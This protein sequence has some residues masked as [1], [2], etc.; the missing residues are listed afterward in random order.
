MIDEAQYAA[1][2]EELRARFPRL[3]L[4]DKG[5]SAMCKAIDALLRVVTLGGQ[6]VFMTR[7]VTT[8]GS[9]IYLPS[10]WIAR[11]PVDRYCVM[12]H[13]AV[14]LEQFRRY[15]LIGM[16]LLYVLFPIP[17]GFAAGR[18]WLEWEAYRETVRATWEIHGQDAARAP[19]FRD[20]IVR[21]FTGPDYGWMWLRGTTVDKALRRLL[22][23][24]ETTH[25]TDQ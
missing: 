18:A 6:S 10:E 15:G 22:S 17:L 21:R 1:Y 2:L 19:G 14:H 9:R 4:I 13:E 3:R 5:E 25:P 23:E 11:P 24:L 12:R 16:T 8:I 7:Y 20:E